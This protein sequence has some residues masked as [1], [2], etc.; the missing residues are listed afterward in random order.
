MSYDTRSQIFGQCIASA[1][2]PKVVSKHGI[3]RYIQIG[4]SPKKLI[5]GLPWY[6]Y[7]YP[8]LLGTKDQDRFCPVREV[9]FRGVDCSDAAGTEFNYA[10]IMQYLN[11]NKTSTGRLYDKYLLS[12]YFNYVKDN[13]V[14]QVW[15]DDP[16][17]LSTKYQYA[18][19]RNLLGVGPYELTFLDYTSNSPKVQQQTKEMWEALMK[20]L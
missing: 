18:K 20:F 16:D 9:P 12:P 6:G 15:Y 7:D 13:V 17:S 11:E 19:E 4:V 10:D 8:C 14:H 1:N 2:A 3:E 5:L